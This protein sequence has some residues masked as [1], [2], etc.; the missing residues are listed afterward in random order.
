MICERFCFTCMPHTHTHTHCNRTLPH[1]THM[2]YSIVPPPNGQLR[3]RV[4]CLR[5]TTFHRHRVHIARTSMPHTYS[6][7]KT[8]TVIQ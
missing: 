4:R 8:V 5:S 6:E 3:S 1:H 7:N 2:R